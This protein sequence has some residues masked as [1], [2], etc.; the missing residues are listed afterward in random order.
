MSVCT[1]HTLIND[2]KSG[3][4][5]GTF[6]GGIKFNSIGIALIGERQGGTG[7]VA[8]NEIAEQ[9]IRTTQ[10]ALPGHMSLFQ[11]VL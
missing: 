5:N 10:D 2:T 11:H 3:S 7:R 8:S 9:P 6:V 4:Q 1:D